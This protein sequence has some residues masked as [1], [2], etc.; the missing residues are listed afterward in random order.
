[1]KKVLRK[2]K[3]HK[4]Y[5]WIWNKQKH[6]QN[7]QR[8]QNLN[9]IKILQIHR[10]GLVGGNGGRNEVINIKLMPYIIIFYFLYSIAI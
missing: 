10:V 7:Q 5:Q 9:N 4:V 3:E 2:L 6:S 8:K 1:M